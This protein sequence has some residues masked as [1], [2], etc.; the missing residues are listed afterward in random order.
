MEELCIKIDIA[1]E[2]RERFE[3]ALARVVQE[4]V[5][6]LELLIAEEIIS[7]S[8]FTEEDAEELSKKVKLSMHNNL[9]KK[10][11]R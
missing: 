2:L 10:E 4:L 5:D 7:E 9:K 3:L 8:K 1:P 6:R 11:L